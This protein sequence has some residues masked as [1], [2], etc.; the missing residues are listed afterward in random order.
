[1]AHKY[2]FDSST[3][4]KQKRSLLVWKATFSS[5]LFSH[6][7]K[8]ADK[9]IT[10]QDFLLLTQ[11]IYTFYQQLDFIILHKLSWYKFIDIG[12]FRLQFSLYFVFYFILF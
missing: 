9:E 12:S 5:N 3:N 11:S 4:L 7:L 1:M 2:L 8:L 6:S 10:N